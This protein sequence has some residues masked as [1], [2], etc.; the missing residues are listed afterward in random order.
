MSTILPTTSYGGNAT[1]TGNKF[2]GDGYYGRQDGLHTVA[3]FLDQ[4]VGNV[5]IQA[6]LA[7]DPAD[8]DWFDVVDTEHGDGS[9]IV[10]EN[11]FKNFSGNFV[12]IR[13]VV[14]E[15]SA[16]TINKIHYNH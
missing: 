5:K 9:T 6:T 1:V 10:T 2:K 15:F 7:T 16:G 8:S 13:A 3:Y 14:S 4:F 11:V 12:W